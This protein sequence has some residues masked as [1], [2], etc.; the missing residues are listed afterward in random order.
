MA[1]VAALIDASG[2]ASTVLIAHDWGAVVAW[3]F[4]IRRV[5]PL[6]KLVILNVPHPLPF[7]AATPIV[8]TA[9]AEVLVCRLLPASVAA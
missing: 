3:T 2:A 4:A 1:D 6:E 8:E 9:D 5:R 7:R